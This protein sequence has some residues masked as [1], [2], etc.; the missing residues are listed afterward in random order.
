MTAPIQVVGVGDGPRMTVDMLVGNPLFI[1]TRIA[2]L[3]QDNF[4]TDVVFR[5]GGGNTN[6]IVGFEEG[7]PLFLGDDVADVAEFS[8]IPVGEGQRG[9]P[10]IVVG[11][12][13]GLGIRV[14]KEMRDENRLDD[15]N[16]KIRQLTNT[17]IRA[18][19]RALRALLSNPAIP[20]IPATV[21]WGTPGSKI[22]RDI[23]NAEEE[24]ASATPDQAAEEDIYGF[25]PDS[26]IMP[27]GIAPVLMDDDDFLKVYVGEVAAESIA[28]TGVLPRM[29]GDLV[30]FKSRF[31]PKD[32]ALVLE[33]NTIGFYSDTRARQ[34]TPLYPEGNGPNGGPTESWRA[35][36]TQ[37]RVL[38][39]DQPKAACWITGIQEV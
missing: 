39:L 35:D 31:W 37:K 8:E 9:I 12:K 20:S 17:W 19:E 15:V 36:G 5:N 2:E 38:G 23:A 29:I 7:V 28:Y 32:R 33:R 1:P 13:Q 26:I 6:G 22:R 14:S 27:G 4:L 34:I 10:R 18:E 25:E 16:R 30:G 11:T 21:A 24:I 3:L